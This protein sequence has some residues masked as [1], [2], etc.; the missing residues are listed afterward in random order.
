MCDR[1]ASWLTR[2]RQEADAVYI[3]GDLFDY[4]YT[5]L[6]HRYPEVMDALRSPKV[7]VMP[8]N[9]DFLLRDSRLQG[10]DVIQPEELVLTMGGKKVLIAHGHT[11]TEAD[12][13]FRLLHR[14]G[15]PLLRIIDAWL[16]VNAKDRCARA[17]VR[18]SAVVRPSSAAIREGI[19]AEHGVDMVI[20]GHLHRRVETDGLI[21]LSAF[22]DTGT[23]LVWDASG[24]RL[25]GGKT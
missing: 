17:L 3:L 1:F 23:W 25:L 9:R 8:G 6:E 21:V 2:A 12:T 20:C 10:I 14:Y 13:G 22:F 19:A 18:S 4:W 7:H 11:L 16:P 24:P 15:W 5:G